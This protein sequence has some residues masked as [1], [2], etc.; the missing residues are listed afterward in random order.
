MIVM[1]SKVH[2]DLLKA[3]AEAHYKAIGSI[4]ANDVTSV[5]DYEAVKCSHWA[6]GSIC[7]RVHCDCPSANDSLMKFRKSEIPFKCESLPCRDSGERGPRQIKEEQVHRDGCLQFRG[8]RRRFQRHRFISITRHQQHV[9]EGESIGCSGC[10]QG[11]LHLQ[12]CCGGFSAL[13]M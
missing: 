11:F 10:R 12:R 8:W 3:A 6:L 4:D 13:K 1:G 2:G 5:A 7:A 9:L